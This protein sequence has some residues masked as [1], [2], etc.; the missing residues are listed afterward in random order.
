MDKLKRTRR[1]R[2]LKRKKFLFTSGITRIN[3]KINPE[4]SLQRRSVLIIDQMLQDIMERICEEAK[5]ACQMSGR[6]TMRAQ[7]LHRGF[8]LLFKGKTVLKH[9]CLG[10]QE[11]INSPGLS[12][13][14]SSAE[15]EWLEEMYES[16]PNMS[17]GRGEG[18][19][20]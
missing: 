3:R 17:R 2:R 11:V 5:V 12:H 6:K 4:L 16:H 20:V 8:K 15:W 7:D 9:V 18:E 1:K 13:G 19:S 10:C 14:K